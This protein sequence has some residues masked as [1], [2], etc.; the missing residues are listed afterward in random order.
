MKELQIL[1][2]GNDSYGGLSGRDIMAICTGLQEVIKP[3]YLDQRIEQSTYLGKKLYEKGLPV[4]VPPGAH[5]IYLDVNKFFPERHW[6]KFAGVGLT[7]ELIRKYAIRGC[8]LGAFGFEFD[9]RKNLNEN[10]LPPNLVR[11]AIP[12]NVY[13]KEH[14]DY[15]IEALEDIYLNRDK[16]PNMKIIKGADLHLRHFQ[17]QLAMCN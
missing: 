11:F 1:T 6:S 9:Q 2:F 15:T 3:S 4:I 5:A 12:R 8:E 17:S 14:L 10:E 13:S 7:I 16:V